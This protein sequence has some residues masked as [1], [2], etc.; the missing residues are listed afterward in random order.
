MKGQFMISV[1]TNHGWCRINMLCRLWVILDYGFQLG[2]PQHVVAV[3]DHMKVYN[4]KKTYLNK[5]IEET[6]FRNK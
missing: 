2:N 1:A 4:L 5:V 6:R 3:E